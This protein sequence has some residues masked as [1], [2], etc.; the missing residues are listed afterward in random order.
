MAN[1]SFTI[2]HAFYVFYVTATARFYYQIVD[3]IFLISRTVLRAFAP[4]VREQSL[5]S[6]V[7]KFFKIEVE[8]LQTFWVVGKIKDYGP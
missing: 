8:V 4:F 5:L 2:L 6:T 7:R 1:W 3:L